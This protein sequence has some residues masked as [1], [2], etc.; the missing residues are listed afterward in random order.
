[1]KFNAQS[2][3]LMHNEPNAYITSHIITYLPVNGSALYV[4]LV[5]VNVNL[6]VVL[7][8]RIYTLIKCITLIAV[9]WT[10]AILSYS[11]STNKPRHTTDKIRFYYYS[12]FLSNKKEARNAQSEKSRR[13]EIE[14]TTGKWAIHTA[15]TI[16]LN[17]YMWNC[18][19]T[20]CW[21]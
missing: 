5:M 11:P 7:F 15:Y 8:F 20:K 10:I 19:V 13:N 21:C 9:A 2:L 14:A 16:Q 1:M 18:N 6:C 3:T 12:S 17:S 4:H